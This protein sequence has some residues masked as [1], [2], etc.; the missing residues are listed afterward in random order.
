[1]TG[2]IIFIAT[3]GI[4]GA[5]ILITAIRAW[6]VRLRPARE[7]AKETAV[8]GGSLAAYIAACGLLGFGSAGQI[9]GCAASFAVLYLGRGHIPALAA[10][11]TRGSTDA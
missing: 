2:L 7:V 1:M 4:C 10:Y 11:T 9:T 8:T 3:T 5:A 6:Y